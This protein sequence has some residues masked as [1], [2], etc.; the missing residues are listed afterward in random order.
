MT[1]YVPLSRESSQ[2]TLNLVNHSQLFVAASIRGRKTAD[3]L[4]YLEKVLGY[5]QYRK[6]F[7]PPSTMMETISENYN[8]SYAKF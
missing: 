4:I 7:F 1:P 8:Q 5:S 2:V 3:I 6:F